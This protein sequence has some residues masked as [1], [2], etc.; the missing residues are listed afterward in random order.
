MVIYELMTKTMGES[1]KK[2]NEKVKLLNECHNTHIPLSECHGVEK[3][4]KSVIE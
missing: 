3:K 4:E 1:D 2:K